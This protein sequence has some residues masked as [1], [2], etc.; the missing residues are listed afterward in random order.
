MEFIMMDWIKL[1]DVYSDGNIIKWHHY[2]PAQGI[3]FHISQGS[4]SES[5]EDN[6]LQGSCGHK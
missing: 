1:I 4:F 3:L 6:G 5:V 2:L